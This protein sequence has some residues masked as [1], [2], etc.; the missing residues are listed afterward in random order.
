VA[1]LLLVMAHWRL[2]PLQMK[3]LS[4]Q[5]LEAMEFSF[6]LLERRNAEILDNLIGGMLGTTWDAAA[7]MGGD[8]DSKGS[9]G[10]KFTWEF[11]TKKPKVNLP[12]ALALTQNPKFMEH[13]KKLASSAV[14]TAREEPSMVDAPKWL[15]RKK[16]EIVDLSYAPK[17]EFLKIA[18]RFV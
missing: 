15:D 17:A 3:D 6:L 2:T 11:R 8:K 10:K 4:P 7:L 16:E 12:L 18:G 5:E 9:G 1:R 14:N 13:L